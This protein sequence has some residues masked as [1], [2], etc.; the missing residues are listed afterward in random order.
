MVSITN[1]KIS[2]FIFA[3]IKNFSIVIRALL[4]SEHINQFGLNFIY[5]LYRLHDSRTIMFF[6]IFRKLFHVKHFAFNSLNMYILEPCDTRQTKR[7][8]DPARATKH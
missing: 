3:I 7:L 8:I 5:F 1:I 4:S 2:F 6:I